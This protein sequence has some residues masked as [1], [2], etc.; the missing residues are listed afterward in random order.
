MNSS[1]EAKT[2]ERQLSH[3]IS[4]KKNAYFICPSCSR[5]SMVSAEDID[6]YKNCP[7]CGEKNILVK[8]TDE[9]DR[10]VRS[11]RQRLRERDYCKSA[12]D[13]IENKRLALE[14]AMRC[15]YDL[16][17]YEEEETVSLRLFKGIGHVGRALSELEIAVDCFK[18]RVEEIDR[19]ERGPDTM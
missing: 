11:Q 1:Q 12:A 19:K 7:F 2:W 13:N 4:D 9:T 6:K 5:Y 10:K 14:A 8:N 3:I 16:A 15:I 17:D 18:Q